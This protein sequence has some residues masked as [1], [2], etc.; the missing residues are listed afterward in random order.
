MNIAPSTSSAAATAS[1]RPDGPTTGRIVPESGTGVDLPAGNGATAEVGFGS[2]LSRHLDDASGADAAAAA[3]AATSA[4]ATGAATG[5]ATLR[6][7]VAVDPKL[8]AAI[9]GTVRIGKADTLDKTNVANAANVT[10]A[11]ARLNATDAAVDGDPAAAATGGADPAP[12]AASG[13]SAVVPADLFPTLATSATSAPASP[14]KTGAV[15]GAA[16]GAQRKGRLD[17]PATR[18]GDPGSDLAAQLALASQWTRPAD[19]ATLATSAPAST[20]VAAAPAGG[21]ARG[22]LDL[23]AATGKDTVTSGKDDGVAARSGAPATGGVTGAVADSGDAA[24]PAPVA[25][26]IALRP[27]RSPSSPTPTRRHAATRSMPRRY[28]A[29]PSRRTPT[30]LPPAISSRR[31]S[32]RRSR[33][34]ARPGACRSV[35]RVRSRLHPPPPRMRRL[36]RRS[37]SSRNRSARTA[38]RTRSARQRCEWPPTT[39]SPRRSA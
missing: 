23:K 5:A 4:A 2:L 33:C 22:N 34:T 28:P 37:R 18:D 38:G 32:R 7:R 10:N 39:C 12:F 17:D 16:D 11:A 26:T 20:A 36:P 13:V 30:P 19:A 15:Q 24:G 9:D 21:A 6:G 1:T 3:I 35:P 29:L 31:A 27:P 14:G 8:Q 25:K